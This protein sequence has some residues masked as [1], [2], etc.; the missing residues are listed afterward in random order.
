MDELPQP[1][2]SGDPILNL[3]QFRNGMY[4]Q[5]KWLGRIDYNL[6]SKSALS[7]I[8]N[9]S[10]YDNVLVADTIYGDKNALEVLS[11]VDRRTKKEKRKK[12]AVWMGVCGLLALCLAA[13]FLR[14]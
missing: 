14:R 13:Y 8:Y 2:F 10:D 9:S 12:V 7:F 1:N 5:K 11:F 6:S 4:R 3:R